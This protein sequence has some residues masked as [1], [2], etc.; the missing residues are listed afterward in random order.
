M[1]PLIL[2]MIVLSVGPAITRML[3]SL[4]IAITALTAARAKEPG[5]R[6]SAL[7]TLKVLVDPGP[8]AILDQRHRPQSKGQ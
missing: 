1:P 4:A 7:A 8:Q 3:Y 5:R 2:V 6:R